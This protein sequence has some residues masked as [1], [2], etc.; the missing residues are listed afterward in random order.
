MRLPLLLCLFA[1]TAFAQ[2]KALLRFSIPDEAFTGSKPELVQYLLRPVRPMGVVSDSLPVLPE[3][4]R[5]IFNDSVPLLS[6]D[7]L[8]RYLHRQRIDPA[9]VGGSLQRPV[10]ANSKGTRARYFV[11]HDT[12][13]PNYLLDDIPDS[14]NEASWPHNDVHRIWKNRRLAHVFVGRTG[15]SYSPVPF[16]TAW[17]ATK[18]ESRVLDSAVSKGLFLHIELVQPRQSDPARA[19]G[20]DILA[21]SPGFTE[22]QYDRLALLYCCASARAGYWLLP[23][24]HAVLD[25][26]IPEAHDDPQHFDSALWSRRLQ[27]VV[28]AANR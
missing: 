6:I 8:D 1:S 18:L 24:F 26:G 2:S 22:A 19:A 20:N 28:E 27:S 14:V 17:R 7:A 3:F 13:T 23:T 5:Q 11:I 4:L 15:R 16:D 12:S 21:P 9:D 10:S 25:T